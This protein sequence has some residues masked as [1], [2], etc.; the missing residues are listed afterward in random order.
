MKQTHDSLSRHAPRIHEALGRSEGLNLSEVAAY[1]EAL[2]PDLQTLG[3]LRRKLS[4]CLAR[5]WSGAAN[6]V[7]QQLA[8]H[9]ELTRSQLQRCLDVL[10]ER[11][12]R[13]PSIRNV[14]EELRQA[15]EEFGAFTYDRTGRALS[16]QTDPITLEGVELGPFE[17]RLPLENLT[18]GDVEAAVRVIALDPNPAAG[19]EAVTHPH[20]SDGRLC[21]GEAAAPLRA[22]LAAGRLCD[23]LLLV[24][25]VLE[26][27]NPESPYVSLENWDGR[28]CYD[29]GYT[30]NEPFWCECCEHDYCDECIS[31]CRSCD[32]T[33]C[34]QCL[35]SCTR[36]DEPTCESCLEH[37]SRCRD[38]CCPSCLEGGMCQECLEETE[39]PDENDEQ[40]VCESAQVVG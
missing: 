32:T 33:L 25:S 28:A 37:C 36:C 35:D 3:E 31:F 12:P 22:A 26:T 20:V 7:G 15:Q 19:N 2:H 23:A 34:R 24:R 13:H 40:N 4:K 9:L 8:H 16:V 5:R 38:T 30:S 18:E 39:E 10:S 14:Y 29:C 6:R 11:K 27:Y 21:A 1:L 17:V